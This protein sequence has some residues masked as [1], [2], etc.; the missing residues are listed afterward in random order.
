VKAHILV[1]NTFDGDRPTV[2]PG[3]EHSNREPGVQPSTR[4]RMGLCIEQV[5]IARHAYLFAKVLLPGRLQGVMRSIVTPGFH[6]C[7]FSPQMVYKY[8]IAQ[9]SSRRISI[10]ACEYTWS[11]SS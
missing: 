3:N 7:D 10:S 6:S 1:D 2:N 9:K 5:F 8:H 11:I 4:L